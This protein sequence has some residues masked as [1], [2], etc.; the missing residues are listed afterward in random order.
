[1]GDTHFRSNILEQGDDSL[2]IKFTNATFTDLSV[3]TLLSLTAT[4]VLRGVF[5]AS[6]ALTAGATA[7]MLRINSAATPMYIKVYAKT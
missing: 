4:N 1:M 6:A 7:R 2:R 5:V 3:T